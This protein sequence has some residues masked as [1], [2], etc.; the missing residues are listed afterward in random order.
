MTKYEELK[1]EDVEETFNK[2]ISRVDELSTHPTSSSHQNNVNSTQ[3]NHSPPQ[4]GAINHSH[5]NFSNADGVFSNITAKPEATK[6]FEELEPPSYDI[7]E[8]EQVPPYFEATVAAATYGEDGEVLVEGMEVGTPFSFIINVIMSMSFDFIGTTMMA[9]THAARCGS[10][11]GLGITLL[12]YGLF[13]RSRD[14]EAELNEY[15][16]Y[17]PQSGET[18]EHLSSQNINP[19]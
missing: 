4:D 19:I 8:S 1:N 10:R 17:D 14:V 11:M 9:T 2:H 12:R 16:Y 18:A 15:R 7:S 13:I 6:P 3:L 5:Y